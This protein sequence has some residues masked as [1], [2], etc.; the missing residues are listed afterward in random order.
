MEDFP[1]QKWKI[2]HI[3]EGVLNNIIDCNFVVIV[4]SKKIIDIFQKRFA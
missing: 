2:F 3:K 4:M 1:F